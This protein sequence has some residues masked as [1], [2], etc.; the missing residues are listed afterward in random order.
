MTVNNEIY[1]HYGNRWYEA[2][3]D[4]VALLRAE[5]KFKNP[6]IKG[7]LQNKVIPFF[8]SEPAAILDVGC[9]AGFL[10]NYLSGEL[11]SNHVNIT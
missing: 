6:W 8:S 7:I 5:S 4:P 10:T 1:H 3:D 2:K 11:D 9:G